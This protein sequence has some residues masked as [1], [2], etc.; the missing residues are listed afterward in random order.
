MSAYEGFDD[1]ETKATVQRLKVELEEANKDLESD[2]YDRYIQDSEKLLDELYTQ[3]EEILNE[4][5][6]NI[7]YLVADVINQINADASVIGSTITDSANQVG[8][9]LSESMQTI[10][11]SADGTNGII[12]AYSEN[13]S[14]HQ[15]TVK[16]ALDTIKGNLTL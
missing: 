6:D 5:L 13:F 9:T 16:D 3:Y 2:E 10:W 1:E 8:Y 14:S 4:R 11:N 15:T 12:T 7:D